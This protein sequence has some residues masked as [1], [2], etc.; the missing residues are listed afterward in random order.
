MAAG[1]GDQGWGENIPM[2]TLPTSLEPVDGK[3][4]WTGKETGSA[5]RLT[6]ADI[7]GL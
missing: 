6:E 1:S 2:F 4:H 5:S 3:M 7:F